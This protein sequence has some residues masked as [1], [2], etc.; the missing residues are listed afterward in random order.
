MTMA[1][2]SFDNSYARDLA[3]MY[4]AQRPAAVAAPRLLRLNTALAEELGL[5]PVAL[6]PVAAE[7]FSGA[8]LPE[9][10][11][12]IAQAYAGHQFGGFSTQLGDGR[13]LLLGE[14]I[15]SHG[16]RRDIALKGSGRTPFSRGGDGLAAV[17]PVLREYLIGEA[18]AALGVPTTR[19]LAA[20]A[21]GG[22]VWRDSGALPGAVLTRVAS[23]HLR[24]GTFQF[25]AARGQADMVQ[26]LADYAM[27]RHDPELRGAERPYLAFF[28]AV[29]ARQ[30]RL[31]AQWM[32]LG[33]IHGVMNTDN[34]TISG[35][36]IDYGPCAFM[37]AYAPGTVFSSID[38]QGRYAYGNQ[39]AILG[40]NLARLAETLLPL[41]DA[42][43]KTAVDLAN[44]R[45]EGIAALYQA[46]WLAVMRGKLGLAG[47]DAGDAALAEGFLAALTG[48]DFTRGFGALADAVRDPGRLHG[49][50]GDRAALE[51]WLPQW[52]ARLAP[53]AP[54]RIRAANP[55]YIPRNQR[56]EE[57]LSAAEAGDMAP[58]ERLLAVITD[59]YTERP[60]LEAYALP[61]PEA[62]ADTFRTFCG[63]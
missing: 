33:F 29:V 10:A 32:G 11:E 25:F 49:L 8:H 37:E 1:D 31:I 34:M 12:P 52:Q 39:P 50:F 4:V 7:V 53:D 28:D 51:R 63:T 5:D 13:A 21:T 54:A 41:F 57:A 22:Q 23:S 24:V 30:A 43:E 16:A 2:F 55:I 45:L 18:M 35:E 38:R 20:V 27:A 62:F 48:T 47:E 58:F 61:A 6:A 44:A 26:R 3:G 46:E 42:D 9:G 60:G 40:W 17:G 36:T 15:D 19:A 14:V 56:V 59:P